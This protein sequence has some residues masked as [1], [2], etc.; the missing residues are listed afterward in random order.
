MTS[1]DR[2]LAVAHSHPLY[3][4]HL[5]GVTHLRDMTIVTK[6]ELAARINALIE[7][8]GVG[9]SVYWSSSGGSGGRP[10]CFPVAIEE[11]HLQRRRLATRLAMAGVLGPKSVV[12]NLFPSL[13]MVRS[14]EIFNEFTELCGGTALPCPINRGTNN[15]G[16]ADF[17]QAWNVAERFGANV[18][19]G[20]PSTLADFSHW[21]GKQNRRPEFE[22][23]L[24]AGEFLHPRRRELLMNQFGTRRFT[25]VYGSAE[26]GIIGYSAHVGAPP[27]YHVPRDLAVIEIPD[28]N[29]SGVGHIVVTNLVR[30]RFPLVRFDT[31]DVGR[32]VETRDNEVLLELHARD[33][34]TFEFHGAYHEHSSLAKVLDPWGDWQLVLECDGQG[35][36]RLTCTI[37]AESGLSTD[38]EQKLF[39]SLQTQLDPYG[40]ACIE[41]RK[42]P[43]NQFRT[44]G[45]STKRPRVVD[46]R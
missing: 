15:G 32:I 41:L 40:D 43:G 35:C 29:A 46:I 7:S 9:T 14:L 3:R 24:F 12:L 26:M 2:I 13:A 1:L 10:L 6:P 23:I 17:E 22:T 11:N 5:V 38:E 25:A 33:E 39:A 28:A 20:M 4:E 30:T 16:T 37:A 8:D 42:I 45:V 34:K 21:C 27:V 36:E 18:L 44:A 19:A 31:G